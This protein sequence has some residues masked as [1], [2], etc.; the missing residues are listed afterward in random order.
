MC[1][2]ESYVPV[3]SPMQGKEAPKPHQCEPAEVVFTD[4]VDA[5]HATVGIWHLLI[6]AWGVGSTVRS[7]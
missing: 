6:E 3:Q 4:M 5:A 7:S 2:F 1:G